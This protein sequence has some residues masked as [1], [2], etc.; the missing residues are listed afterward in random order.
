VGDAW[1][2]D[3]RRREKAGSR[4]RR[5]RSSRARSLSKSVTLDGLM[6][7][8]VALYHLFGDPASPTPRA[9]ARD[10]PRIATPERV[11]A[12]RILDD[13][14]R[15]FQGR[16]RVD[17]VGRDR[18]RARG[19][20]RSRVG[21]RRAYPVGR[22]RAGIAPNAADLA[23]RHAEANRVVLAAGSITVSPSNGGR[24]SIVLAV[25]A[26]TPKG[27]YQVSLFLDSTFGSRVAFR[28]LLVE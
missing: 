9:D 27:R 21:R 15:S 14:L 6:R 7:D 4:S 2:R 12:G 26:D 10:G 20:G 11:R 22:S 23:R 19:R 13:R 5:S 18:T 17:R 24:P 25:P 3:T 28:P 8:H 1:L 16:G